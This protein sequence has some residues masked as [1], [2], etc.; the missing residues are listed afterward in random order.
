MAA[1]GFQAA[2]PDESANA[3]VKLVRPHTEYMPGQLKDMVMVGGVGD[4]EDSRDAPTRRMWK[5]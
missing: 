3:G 1:A 4:E 5:R 2:E